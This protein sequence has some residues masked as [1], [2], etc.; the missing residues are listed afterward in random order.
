MV[1]KIH[2]KNKSS[3]VD[4]SKVKYSDLPLCKDGSPRKKEFVLWII[5]KINKTIPKKNR[6]LGS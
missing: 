2:Q 3:E 4:Y 5:A 6:T 1:K